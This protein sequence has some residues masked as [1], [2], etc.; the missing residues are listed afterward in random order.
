MLKKIVSAN[1]MLWNVK[2]SERVKLYRL[3]RETYNIHHHGTRVMM[4]YLY[5]EVRCT[6]ARPHGVTYKKTTMIMITDVGISK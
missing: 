1:F 2:P 4:E 6:S 3:F 5:P